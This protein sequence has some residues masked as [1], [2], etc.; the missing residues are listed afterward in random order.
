MAQDISSQVL[1]GI[2]QGIILMVLNKK[3]EYGYGLSQEM[4]RYGLSSV[5]KGTIYP[6][7][8]AMEKRGFITGKRRAST[9]GP[10]RK[11]YYITAVGKEEKDR[12]IQE[13]SQLQKSV[14]TLIKEEPHD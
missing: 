8:T 9:L 5:P 13:W 7:L 14:N 12:F 11:Y 1:K 3:P 6:L 4:D 10:T 2:L